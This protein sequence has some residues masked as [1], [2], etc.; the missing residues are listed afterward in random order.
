MQKQLYHLD[1]CRKRLS[2]VL[3]ERSQATDLICQA[4]SSVKGS[5]NRS[6]DQLLEKPQTPPVEPLGPY[7]PEAANSI[8]SALQAR[9]TSASLR[10]TVNEAIEDASQLQHST[11]FSVNHGLTQKVA[12]TVNIKVSFLESLWNFTFQSN[13]LITSRTNLP[14]CHSLATLASEFRSGKNGDQ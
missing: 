10:K 8:S 13:F 4:V 11:H 12:E 14:S 2:A 7:T 1:S 9:E 5:P 3:Q 6:K